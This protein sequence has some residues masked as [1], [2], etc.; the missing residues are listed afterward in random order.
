LI[1]SAT[2]LSNTGLIC[3]GTLSF[4]PASGA[5]VLL[6]RPP[7]EAAARDA[8]VDLILLNA[9]PPTQPGGRTWLWQRVSVRGLEQARTRET[10]ADFLDALTQGHG[11]FQLTLAAESETR[12]TL[13]VDPVAASLASSEGVTAWVRQAA[14]TITGPLTGVVAHTR[15]E[16]HLTASTRRRELDRRWMAG[17]PSQVQGPLIGALLFGLALIRFWVTR[18]R[19]RVIPQPS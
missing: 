18:R 17:V 14:S 16:A 6:P 15:I 8:D 19:L 1:W 4:A 7:I 12:V 3:A 5:Q 11:L 9:D 10:L 13:T 2:F